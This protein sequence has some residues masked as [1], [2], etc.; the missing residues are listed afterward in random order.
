MRRLPNLDLLE[1]QAMELIMRNEEFV[2][3]LKSKG[4]RR[5][6]LDA[7]VFPQVWGYTFTAFDVSPQGEATCGGCAM[8][9]AYTVVF[10]EPNL[11]VYIVFVDNRMAYQ[12]DHPTDEFYD[13]L[14]NRRLASVSDAKKRY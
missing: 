12:V 9:K 6:D 8:T 14:K 3:E 4:V 13:D 10:R 5:L 11:E 1:Y 2:A 7:E